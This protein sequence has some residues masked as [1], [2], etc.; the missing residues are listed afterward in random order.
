MFF[1]KIEK[2]E[3]PIVEEEK[4]ILRKQEEKSYYLTE[5]GELVLS[6]LESVE[7]LLLKDDCLSSLLETL[8]SPSKPL[9]A[10]DLR[11]ILK[12]LNGKLTS[13]Q[14]LIKTILSVVPYENPNSAYLGVQQTFIIEEKQKNFF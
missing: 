7:K 9:K 14:S 6:I 12:L 3:D 10:N 11:A 4:E 13:S 2:S 1:N 8:K 5:T